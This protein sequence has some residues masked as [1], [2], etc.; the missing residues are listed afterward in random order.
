MSRANWSLPSGFRSITAMLSER[1]EMYGNGCAGSTAS[2]VSTGNTWFSKYS[3]KSFCSSTE[4]SFHRL[5]V[6]FFSR[7]AGSSTSLNSL[8]WRSCRRCAS[9]LISLSTSCGESPE[10][11]ITASPVAIRRFSPATRTMK[12]SS[13]FEAKMAIK[14]T[15]SS[16][17]MVG[18]SASS[19]TRW[20]KASQDSSRSRKRS[21]GR[22]P[23]SGRSMAMVSSDI[24]SILP[25]TAK[26]EVNT[27]WR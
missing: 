27:W 7:R 6:I 19:R 16:N 4:R 17:C 12:N 2:G 5:S 14:L 18:S 23:K 3:S 21:S 25:R 26:R 8:A 13:R 10:D 20:L 24:S 9:A 15:R 11:A 22:S 1:P